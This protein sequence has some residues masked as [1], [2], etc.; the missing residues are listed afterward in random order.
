MVRTHHLPLQIRRS[1]RSGGPG[2]LRCGSGLG[3]RWPH[4]R[5]LRPSEYGQVSVL[6]TVGAVWRRIAALAGAWLSS[7]W[8]APAH[9]LAA[10]QKVA[11]GRCGPGEQPWSALLI[12]VRQILRL[13]VGDRRGSGLWS[14]G[15]CDG[16]P[17]C[18]LCE[19]VPGVCGQFRCNLHGEV[20]E[21]VMP[22]QPPQ[23]RL[24][25]RAGGVGV[26]P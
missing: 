24:R 26:T 5:R 25:Q 8:P 9:P 1:D 15:C 14:V 13:R 18:P 6:R 22:R 21:P 3:N 12:D 10:R 7:G 4:A 2:L 20:G 16:W 11:W 19:L 23:A 17:S